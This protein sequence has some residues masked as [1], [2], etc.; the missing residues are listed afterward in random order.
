LSA[1]EAERLRSSTVFARNNSTGRV[2]QICFVM[3]RGAFDDPIGGCDPPLS[4]WG[5]EGIYWAL[6]DELDA[7]RRGRP[8]IVVARIDVSAR[9]REL[10]VFPGIAKLFV[11]LVLNT[12]S[13]YADVHLHAPVPP[14]D[15]IDIWHP[16]DTEYDQHLG[17]PRV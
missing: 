12:E 11:G 9:D 5:G 2:G 6:G 4:L 10:P 8:T 17:L 16:G 13:Q 1:P 14:G 15:I 3:G 7:P